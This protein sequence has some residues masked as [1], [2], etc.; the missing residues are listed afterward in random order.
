MEA[1]I[2]AAGRGSRF[3]AL[4]SNTPKPLL[5]LAGIPI[6]ERL[7]REAAQIGV[8]RFYVCVGYLGQQIVDTFGAGEQ[9]GVEIQYCYPEIATPE[10]AFAAGLKY[11]K[12][13]TFFCLCGDTYIGKKALQSLKHRFE[14]HHADAVFALDTDNDSN[15]NRV[16]LD[17]EGR[18]LCPSNRSDAWPIAYDLIIKTEMARR[19]HTETPFTNQMRD[20]ARQYRLE[21]ADIKLVNINTEIALET[22]NQKFRQY[23]S[24]E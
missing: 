9:I 15:V 13:H 19:F 5:K 10:S 17:E 22:M 1:I 16:E 2:L 23:E 11:I 7:M 21:A 6:M 18:I 14:R 20:L 4:T 8:H 3:G 12:G 24:L